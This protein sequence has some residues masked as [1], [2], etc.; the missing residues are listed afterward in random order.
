MITAGLR[1]LWI[2]AAGGSVVAQFMADR[3]A[4]DTKLSGDLMSA[5]SQVMTGIYLVSLALG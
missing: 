2:V 3:T 5:H 1:P 4:V